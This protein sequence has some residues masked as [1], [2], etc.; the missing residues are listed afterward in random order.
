MGLYAPDWPGYIDLVLP[1]ELAH[2]FLRVHLPQCPNF[3]R[4]A[5]NIPQQ[6]SVVWTAA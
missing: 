4:L 3:R 2:A 5:A 6:D 1:A